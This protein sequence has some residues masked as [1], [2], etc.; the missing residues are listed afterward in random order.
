MRQQVQ[1]LHA[2]ELLVV[3]AH[4]R[5]LR[6]QVAVHEARDALALHRAQLLAREIALSAGDVAEAQHV[7]HAGV[8]AE[9]EILSTVHDGEGDAILLLR[10]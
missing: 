4:A 9:V 2:P 8:L 5:D 1:L 10:R 7:L 3:A 6:A